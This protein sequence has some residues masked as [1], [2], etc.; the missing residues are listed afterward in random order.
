MLK[1]LKCV[2]DRLCDFSVFLFEAKILKDGVLWMSKNEILSKK[3]IKGQHVL[4]KKMPK[5]QW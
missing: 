2:C 3:T 5:R 1:K 4:S